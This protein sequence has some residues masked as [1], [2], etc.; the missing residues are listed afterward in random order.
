MTQIENP[1]E[2]LV[3][4]LL[5]IHGILRH[6]LSLISA[7]AEQVHDGR[8]PELIRSEID[9]LQTKSPLWQLKVNCIYYCRLVHAHHTG[10]DI[11]IFPALR[12]A[13]PS[14]EPVVDRL[15]ADHRRVSDILDQVD[16]A[17][18]ALV[19]EDTRA[20][21]GRLVAALRLLSEHLLAHLEFE[22]KAISP[23]LRTWRSWP[24]F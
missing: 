16:D 11:H 12:R 4:E 9:H 13:D 17:A 19:E 24:F 1:G 15:E 14:M 6:D 23:T 22:E 5:W 8:D 21:R 18:R 2:H 10:E 20:V 7:L 3:Q